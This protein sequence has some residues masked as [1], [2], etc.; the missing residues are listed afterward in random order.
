MRRSAAAPRPLDATTRL[1]PGRDDAEPPVVIARAPAEV[2]VA[3]AADAHEQIAVHRDRH[4]HHQRPRQRWLQ[5]PV[6]EPDAIARQ[7]FFNL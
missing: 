2:S 6:D 4:H 5:L 1:L 3:N 7:V